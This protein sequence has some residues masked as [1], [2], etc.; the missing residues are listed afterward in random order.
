MYLFTLCVFIVKRLFSESTKSPDFDPSMSTKSIALDASYRDPIGN[1]P[2]RPK[3]GIRR[4]QDDD[5]DWADIDDDVMLP[6]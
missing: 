4:Q 1:L 3:T 6:E 5:E 2:V